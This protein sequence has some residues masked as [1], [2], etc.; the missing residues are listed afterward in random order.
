MSIECYIALFGAM[1]VRNIISGS[2]VFTMTTAPI[3]GGFQRGAAMILGLII[4]DY[5]FILLAISGQA[6]IAESM[7]NT[8]TAIKYMCRLLNLDGYKAI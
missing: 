2:A 8:F 7:G 5:F 6:F 3:A 1:F 4:A